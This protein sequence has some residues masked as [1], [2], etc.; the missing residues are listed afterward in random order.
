MLI[1]VLTMMSM[2]IAFFWDIVLCNLAE[3]FRRFGG[4]Y[5]FHASAVSRVH[6]SST[7]ENYNFGKGNK[8]SVAF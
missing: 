3:I 2:K 4:T 8:Y 6:H 1:E 7:E 5:G